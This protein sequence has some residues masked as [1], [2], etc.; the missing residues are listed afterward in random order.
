VASVTELDHIIAFLAVVPDFDE[1]NDFSE[2]WM[3][4]PDNPDRLKN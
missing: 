1:R 3:V 2:Q 4:G